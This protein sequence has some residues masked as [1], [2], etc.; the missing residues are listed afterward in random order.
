MTDL[1]RLV[2]GSA[3][4]APHFALTKEQSAQL[5]TDQATAYNALIDRYESERNPPDLYHTIRQM[6]QSLLAG[7]LLSCRLNAPPSRPGTPVA[8]SASLTAD[9]DYT[10]MTT[11]ILLAHMLRQ[12]D[13][14]DADPTLTSALA[15]DPITVA[16]DAFCSSLQHLQTAHLCHITQ[17]PGST[18][19]QQLWHSTVLQN[20]TQVQQA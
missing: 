19:N 4:D 5:T 3:Y 13:L 6:G 17:P 1:P 8:H 20:R 11:D 15:D 18:A 10:N 14:M 16:R 7:V 9:T 12:L 2:V